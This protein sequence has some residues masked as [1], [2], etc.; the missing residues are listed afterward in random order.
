MVRPKCRPWLKRLEGRHLRKNKRVF[1]CFS[2][3]SCFA[4]VLRVI[5]HDGCCIFC[6]T[7]FT[8][9]FVVGKSFPPNHSSLVARF[10]LL[11]FGGTFSGSGRCKDPRTP[12]PQGPQNPSNCRNARDPETPALQGP[13]QLVTF[14]VPISVSCSGCGSASLTDGRREALQGLARPTFRPRVEQKEEHPKPYIIGVAKEASQS[15]V[16]S[17]ANLA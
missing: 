4:R 1:V 8:L 7:I 16:C 15:C 5:L 3:N 6:L 12:G 9:S 13:R 11:P 17:A 2:G 14:A 10:V